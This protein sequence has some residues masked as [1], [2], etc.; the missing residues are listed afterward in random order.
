MKLFHRGVVAEAV[1]P[2]AGD[3]VHT[4]SLHAFEEFPAAVGGSGE[5]G[6]L[7]SWVDSGVRGVCWAG[8][9][10]NGAE[11]GA[12]VEGH[13]VIGRGCGRSCGV[14][15]R[16]VGAETVWGEIGGGFVAILR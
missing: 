4:A 5:L 1:R 12:V 8:N 6:G 3:E 16:G 9:G 7:D 15:R 10:G 13:A 14:G 2:P 11:I